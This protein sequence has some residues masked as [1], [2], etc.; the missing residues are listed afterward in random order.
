MSVQRQILVEDKI[1]AG[2]NQNI[3]GAMT[4]HRKRK[5]SGIFLSLEGG[6]EREDAG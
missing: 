3:T 1:D 4:P 6:H 2:V 5:G